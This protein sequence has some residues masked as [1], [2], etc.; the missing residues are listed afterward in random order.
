MEHTDQLVQARNT[1]FAHA[2]KGELSD[3]YF[4]KL[5]NEIENSVLYLSQ[6][7]STDLERTRSILELREKS[8][9]ESMCLEIQCLALRQ[10]KGDETVIEEIREKAQQTV[11]SVEALIDVKL[12]EIQSQITILETKIK[13]IV[14]KALSEYSY[15][16]RN[17]IE[18][19]RMEIEEHDE[20]ETYVKTSAVTAATDLLRTKNLLILIGKAGIGKS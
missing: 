20:D 4:R 11:E 1:V 13:D 10:T 15:A 14:G 6:I 8:L 2:I 7:T 17:I 18:N 5:W 19:T 16:A 3:K 9:E 12:E